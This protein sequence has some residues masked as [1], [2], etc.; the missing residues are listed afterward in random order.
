MT[1][2]IQSRGDFSTTG[3]GQTA[4]RELPTGPT[5]LT[6]LINMIV[7]VA[8]TATQVPVAD[9][10]TYISAV[11]IRADAD[12]WVQWDIEGLLRY[13]SQYGIPMRDGILPIETRMPWAKTLAGE[14]ESVHGT[15]GLR[16]YSVEVDIKAGVNVERLELFTHEGAP[17]R[18]DNYFSVRR[19]SPT[20]TATGRLTE[21]SIKPLPSGDGMPVRKWLAAIM[22]NS[23]D[24]EEIEVRATDKAG[25]RATV[26]ET[27]KVVREWLYKD[28]GRLLTA[29]ATLID[30]TPINQVVTATA[31]GAVPELFSMDISDFE[32]DL[33]WSSAP[34]TFV[35]HEIAIRNAA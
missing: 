3:A 13:N 26:Y 4:T 2:R 16:T 28:S 18:V 20:H 22:I 27:N 30:M 25:N 9:W 34:G 11:R 1:T 29:G 5:Y 6:H 15:L 7:V 17:Q 14:V 33:N 23:T 24:L 8:G 10:A 32:L 35:M 31:A 21:R 19:Y 12:N